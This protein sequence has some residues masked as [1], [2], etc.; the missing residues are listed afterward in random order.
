MHIE[1]VSVDSVEKNRKETFPES[2]SNV[3][4]ILDESILDSRL[5]LIPSSNKLIQPRVTTIP[6]G[7]VLFN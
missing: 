7:I 2:S 1:V 4:D 3:I 5:L 6:R